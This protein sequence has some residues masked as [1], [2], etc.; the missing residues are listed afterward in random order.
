MNG[1]DMGTASVRLSWDKIR[2]AFCRNPI[3]ISICQL[4]SIRPLSVALGVPPV[5]AAWETVSRRPGHPRG[6]FHRLC[7]MRFA[8]LSLS[9]FLPPVIDPS[10][11]R[12][13]CSK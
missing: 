13:Y 1:A 12:A 11:P 3:W 10:G 5:S 7:F 4:H 2:N 8:P 6:G 9:S